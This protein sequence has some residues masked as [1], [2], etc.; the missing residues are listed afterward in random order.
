ME[1]S[2]SNISVND[3]FEMVSKATGVS[4]ENLSL[5]TSMMTIFKGN[6]YKIGLALFDLHELTGKQPDYSEEE[7]ASKFVTLQDVSIYFGVN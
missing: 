7:L 1:S 4:S 6:I 5:D 2:V 3:L